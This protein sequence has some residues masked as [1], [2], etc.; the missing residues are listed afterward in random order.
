MS[1]PVAGLLGSGERLHLQHGPIDLI[2][3]AD[4]LAPQ[5]RELAF[6]AAADRFETILQE[7][8]SELPLLRSVPEARLPIGAVARRMYRAVKRHAAGCFVTPMAAVAGSVADEVL[9]AMLRS[10]PLNRAYVNNGGDIALHL[11]SGTHFTTAMAGLSGTDLGRAI[12]PAESGINGIATSGQG[13]RSL[14]LGI[15]DAVTVLAANAADADVA[16]TLI[17]N[18][19]DLPGHPSINRKPANE[20]QPDSDLGTRPVV[21]G[22][23]NLT[24]HECGQALQAGMLVAT[25]MLSDGLIAGAAL[26][27]QGEQRIVGASC[28]SSKQNKQMVEYA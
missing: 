5:T 8:V 3:G 7:I 18:A 14:S 2:I 22:R 1:G 27:L 23:G 9:A 25:R 13:G 16:A 6:R 10:T 4:P 28:L 20:I 17:A 26:H 12:I 21:T 24:F 11:E 15:A 19:V